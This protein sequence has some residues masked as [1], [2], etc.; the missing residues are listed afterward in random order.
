VHRR[1]PFQRFLYKDSAGLRLCF[2]YVAMRLSA[3]KVSSVAR[4]AWATL[5]FNVVVVLWGAFV[6]A[7][8]SGAGC[9]NRWPNCGGSILGTS[10][11]AQT[12]IEFTHRMT[13]G[14]ALLM[15]AILLVWCWRATSK[16]NWARY[17]AL[18]ATAFLANEALLGAALVLLGHVARDQ[19]A[20]RTL[21]LCLHFGNTL[22]LLGAL[23]LTAAWLQSNSENFTLTKKSSDV[24]AVVIGLLAVLAIGMTGAVAALGDTLFPAT[25]L[26]ASVLQDFTSNSPARL[27]FRLLHPLLAVIAVTFVICLLLKNS[28][29]RMRQS[30]ASMALILLLFAEIGIGLLNVL[31][32]TPVW[33]QILHLLVADTIWISLVLAS[34]ALV[35]DDPYA[36]S[37]RV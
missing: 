26:R 5:C 21:F 33:V 2:C 12:I 10:A 32:L 28:S 3:E 7:T 36:R 17:S 24:S 15:V 30:R 1:W 13:S 37:G 19:S 16:G 22:L 31:L 14:L 20:G 4:F 6:R 29:R 9:G 34:A 35:L 25:S 27:H 11:K 8:G 23:A 18:L